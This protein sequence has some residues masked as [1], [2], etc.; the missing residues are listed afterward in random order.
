MFPKDCRPDIEYC[1]DLD[2]TLNDL[3][4]KEKLD[5]YLNNRPQQKSKHLDKKD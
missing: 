1:L 2:I 5:N 3:A 4:N